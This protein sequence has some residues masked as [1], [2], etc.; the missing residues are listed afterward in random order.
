M[1]PQ[2][3]KHHGYNCER[4]IGRRRP[5]T[6]P[7]GR[8]QCPPPRLADSEVNQSTGE[9]LGPARCIRI[10]VCAL[11]TL[12]Q[13]R[14]AQRLTRQILTELRTPGAH[15]VRAPEPVLVCRPSIPRPK[16]FLALIVE[17]LWG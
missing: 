15:A 17:V 4:T 1:L 16:K 2:K 8:P 13:H 7:R 14:S 10:L 3:Q 12:F 11:H 5:R 6:I 9:L